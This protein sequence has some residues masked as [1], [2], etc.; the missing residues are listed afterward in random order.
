M[1]KSRRY[2]K[3]H[4]ERTTIKRGKEHT[5]RAKDCDK[6]QVAQQASR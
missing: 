6:K 1:I 5:S 4:E 3:H 2:N